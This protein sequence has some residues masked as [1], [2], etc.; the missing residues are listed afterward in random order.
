MFVSF[1]SEKPIE[2]AF[3]I[4]NFLQRNDFEDGEGKPIVAVLKRL[5]ML[6]KLLCVACKKLLLYLFQSQSV[7]CSSPESGLHAIPSLRVSQD[8]RGTA[9]NHLLS[10]SPLPNLRNN[11]LFIVID[12]TKLIMFRIT[13]HNDA[14]CGKLHIC[15]VAMISDKV[16]ANYFHTCIT[17]T[18]SSV[19]CPPTSVNIKSEGYIST[20]VTCLNSKTYI[21]WLTAICS[22]PKANSVIN[23]VSVHSQM[24]DRPGNI[25]IKLVVINKISTTDPIFMSNFSWSSIK[26]SPHVKFDTIIKTE[27]VKAMSPV[28]SVLRVLTDINVIKNINTSG[29]PLLNYSILLQNVTTI[30]DLNVSEINLALI[31]SCLYWFLFHIERYCTRTRFKLTTLLI[32]PTSLTKAVSTWRPSS[33]LPLPLPHTATTSTSTTPMLI[34]V[35]IEGAGITF[36]KHKGNYGTCIEVC[37][38]IGHMYG[39]IDSQIHQIRYS[40]IDIIQELLKSVIEVVNRGN[41]VLKS[42]RYNLLVILQLPVEPDH[43]LKPHIEIVKEHKRLKSK[44]RYSFYDV[45]QEM[46]VIVLVNS[47]NKFP[48][49]VS[50]NLSAIL[51]LLV[52]LDFLLKP[53]IEIMKEHKQL[54]LKL[55]IIPKI[56]STRNAHKITGNL[57][58]SLC[59]HENGDVKMAV[60]DADGVGLLAC[61]LQQR[62]LVHDTNST[63]EKK[64]L[65]EE[66]SSDTSSITISTSILTLNS[67]FYYC[68]C[69]NK[70][71]CYCHDR[72]DV[73]K[74]R[75]LYAPPAKLDEHY[76]FLLIIQNKGETRRFTCNQKTLFELIN[77]MSQ[78]QAACFAAVRLIHDI[79]PNPGPTNM[80]SN[81]L[82]VVT[83]NCRGLGNIDKTR[84]LLNK[85]YALPTQS[86][87]VV[88][89]QETMVTS[90]K[91]IELAWRGKFVHT[92]G[93]GN[94]KGCITLTNHAVDISNIKHYDNRGHCFDLKISTGEILKVCNIYAPNGYDIDKQVFFHQIFQDLETWDGPTIIAGDLN[95]TLGP[96]ERHA[97][98]VTQAELRVADIITSY[99]TDQNLK[100]CWQGRTGFTWRRGRSMSR[101]DRIFYRL[102]NYDICKFKVTWTLIN[103]DHAGLI[104]TLDHK[105]STYQRNEHVKLDNKV[106]LDQHTLQEL[107]DYVKEQLDTAHWMAPQMK[108]DFAK[109]SVRTKA[110]EI[111][112]RTKR[113]ENMQLREINSEISENM[114]LLTIYTNPQSHQILTEELETLQQQRDNI[115]KAQGN[116]LAERA[117]TKW[118]NEGERSNK[119][120]LN[121]L[122]RRSEANEMNTLLVDNIEITDP[123]AIRGQVTDFYHKLYNRDESTLQIDDNFF[124][125]MFRVE[126]EEDTLISKPVTM[127]E[128]WATLK[129]TKATTPGPDGLSNTY[130]KK[131]WGLLGPLILNAWQCSVATGSLPASHKRSLLRLIPK[132]GKDHKLI[133]NWRPITLSNC[134]HKLIT[135][136]YN[137][138]MLAILTKYINVTQT[139]YIKGRSI[140]DNLRLIGALNRLAHQEENVNAT[141]IALD[142]QKAF[143]SVSHKYIQKTLMA[144]GLTSF[145]PIFQLLYK[146][147]TNDIIINGKIGPGYQ[148]KN[149]VKQGDALSCSLFILAIEPV[150]RNIDRNDAISKITSHRIQFT[151]P[152]AVAYADDITIITQNEQQCVQNIFKE[153]Q[154]LTEASGL[155]L[156]AD[157]TEKYNIYSRNLRQPPEQQ[158]ILYGNQIYTLVNQ[159]TIKINGIIFNRDIETMRE[160]NFDILLGKMSRHFKDWGR[161]SLSLL[162][163]VQIIK[164]FGI[165]QYLYSLAVIDLSPQQWKTVRQEIYKFIWNKNY[166]GRAAPHRIKRKVINTS[167]IKGGFG[168]V[169]MEDIMNAARMK[170]F[171][172][173]MVNGTHPTGELQRVLGG[174]E[175]LKKRARLNI[176]DVT[177]G[178]LHILRAHNIE[179]YATIA[180]EFAHNDLILHKRLLGGKIKD[181]IMVIRENSIEMTTLRRK[182]LTTVADVI[183]DGGASLD[184]LC[185]IAENNIIRHLKIIGRLYM[186]QPLPVPDDT[187]RL[188]DT[189]MQ[190]WH[191]PEQLSSKQIRLILNNEALITQTKLMGLTVESATSLYNKIAK[192]KNIPNRT[193]LL[194]LLNGDVYCG[195]RLY[196]FGLADSDLC[197]RCFQ[198][199]TITHLLLTCPYTAEVWS[200]L[201][202]QPR[203]PHDVFENISSS[204]LEIRA[205]LISALVFRKKTLP[206]AV[207]IKTVMQGFCKGLSRNRATKTMATN[208]VERAEL[209]GQWFT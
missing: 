28:L 44:M 143:D 138:R 142:A 79:E 23:S 26:Q 123:E 64:T 89:L 58:S 22:S 163:K 61:S 70:P 81:K 205:E 17:P 20:P 6:E 133:K 97:R 39:L 18:E 87:M 153:Y 194:R 104:L 129:M 111:M 103:S 51:W 197:I 206:P 47:G 5:Q 156:N 140:A 161:R 54:K 151:W 190:K 181:I 68:H 93:T 207:L 158:D 199:E 150:L 195:T 117:K 135:R 112:A 146:D 86:T 90:C 113:E 24:W 168:L 114:R 119:Y 37:I 21:S 45:L 69:I 55:K 66:E 165:S 75:V 105:T 67:H 200:R 109:M 76:V 60:A 8:S 27:I 124:D 100:D 187:I 41:K 196:R 11:Q 176:D 2:C 98:G 42:V 108:L 170:R 49:A 122:K 110:I 137:A 191:K 72:I 155:S 99:T 193:K 52:K 4:K 95:T 65:N 63:K 116:K 132:A 144:V 15:L 96:N 29:S 19:C 125:E 186:G 92:A 145:V 136:L 160:L 73:H 91:Y 171:A 50:Y 134:D 35:D 180:E 16:I 182:G 80:P 94:S 128:L 53:H 84:L 177:S 131:L 188:Y 31:N 36:V 30:N 48:K 120:F 83:L 141:V 10:Q 179:A 203:T 139:A 85:I 25:T 162:G 115:L 13:V 9:P 102:P 106:V 74:G 174:M 175:H 43:L 183:R 166:E 192:L 209:T 14:G 121:L 7:A 62:P 173:L 164:M 202:L 185:R 157:K 77:K 208:M 57:F 59:T 201:G 198:P 107:T 40:I 34:N 127:D 178:V 154:R 56:V 32:P 3:Y 130:L 169:D 147:L 38:D 172:Y 88:M 46:F 159:N 184:L 204:A 148:I 78:R 71:C 12:E 152:K 167:I 149:G 189:Q 126:E 82:T 118:Y 1:Y 33:A 101:L